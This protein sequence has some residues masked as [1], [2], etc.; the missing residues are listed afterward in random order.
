MS[1]YTSATEVGEK[2]GCTFAR[3]SY[4]TNTW[5]R[6][7]NHHTP[8]RGNISKGSKH[9]RHPSPIRTHVKRR[10]EKE[11]S[12]IHGIAMLRRSLEHIQ[13]LGIRDRHPLEFPVFSCMA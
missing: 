13:Q 6:T 12:Q 7:E 5:H 8:P 10:L 11:S 2:D 4:D 3:P 9:N 1:T